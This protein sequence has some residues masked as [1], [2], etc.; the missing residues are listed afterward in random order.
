MRASLPTVAHWSPLLVAALLLLAPGRASAFI[1]AE[2]AFGYCG[3]HICNSYEDCEICAPDCGE[4]ECGNGYAITEE[5]C[6]TDDFK[7]ETCETFGYDSGELSCTDSCEIDQSDC[8]FDD[9]GDDQVTGEEECDGD[10]L[11]GH[12]CEGYGYDGGELT[13]TSDTCEIDLTG[14]YECGD[15]S[16]A[17]EE[18]CDGLDLKGET[19]QDYGYDNGDLYC[20]SSCEIDLSD[21]FDD[22]CGDGEA[23][24]TEECDWDDFKGL[25]CTDFNYDSGDLYCTDNCEIDLSDCYDDLCGN[26]TIDVSEGEEC[27]DGNHESDDGCSAACLDEYCGDG[28]TNFDPDSGYMDEC[29]DG[30]DN[31]NTAPNACRQDCSEPY[32]GDGIEDDEYGEECDDGNGDKYDGCYQCQ[33][34]VLYCCTQYT[35]DGVMSEAVSENCSNANMRFDPYLC[36]LNCDEDFCQ[37]CGGGGVFDALFCA[38]DY[39]DQ[40]GCA[41]GQ[42]TPVGFLLQLLGFPW[43]FQ[44]AACD[45][46]PACLL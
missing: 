14:C 24:G 45:V 39:C 33:I 13:C 17:D 15:G 12:T 9:C 2:E 25:D 5:E 6:D 8:T 4:C 28:I 40:L 36:Q 23:T 1:T 16:A 22:I 21:C 27:D 11:N 7:G 38:P 19:C 41:A 37:S 30:E 44:A 43:N 18:E 32:C 34:E 42:I 35:L 26:N 20:T 3:D 29:D 46:S 10:D 31:S